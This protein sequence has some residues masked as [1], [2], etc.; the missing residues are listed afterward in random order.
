MALHPKVLE[1]KKRAAPVTMSDLEVD[2]KGEITDTRVIKGYLAVWGVRDYYGTVFV[3]GCCAKSLRLRGVESDAKYKITF[4]YQ[5]DLCEPLSLFDVLKEDDYGLYFETKP[6]DDIEVANRV[7]TQVRSGTLNQFSIG[8]DYVWD[9]MEYN[10]ALDAVMLYEI[11]LFEGSVVTI[12]GN[13]ETYAI[14]GIED[15]AEDLLDDTNYF[16]NTL[17]RNKQLEARQLFA[18]HKAISGEAFEQRNKTFTND[19]APESGLDIKYLTEHF[20]LS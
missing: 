6:L 20:K 12:G 2:Y 5:H 18:R 1:L 17:P 19:T 4:L 3:K 14:R 10:E 16:I 9:K 13:P 7:L 15:K 11:E 8:F